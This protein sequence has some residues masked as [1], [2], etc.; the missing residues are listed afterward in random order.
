MVAQNEIEETKSKMIEKVKKYGRL[1]D[2][3]F[4]LL[5]NF[6]ERGVTVFALSRSFDSSGKTGKRGI[7]ILWTSDGEITSIIDIS[8]DD[9]D[10]LF[11]K[12]IEQKHLFIEV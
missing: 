10:K 2:A 3:A 1:A 11:T 7:Y 12:A 5:K 4:E 6:K 8:T 9:G